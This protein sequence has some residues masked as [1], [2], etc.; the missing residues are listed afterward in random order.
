[1]ST[2][3]IVRIQ[4]DRIESPTFEGR[5]FGDTGPYEKLVG[6]AFAELDPADPLNSGI[7]D[8]DRAPRNAAGKVEYSTEVYIL[9]PVSMARGNRTLLYDVV[10]RGN[11]N[12]LT[13]FNVGAGGANDPTTAT[14]AGDGNLMN[15]G[16]TVVWSG[17]QGDVTRGAGRLGIELP[18]A[19]EADGSPIK[20]WITT[21]FV[22][23]EPSFSVPVSFDRDSRD[24]RP[25]PAVTES[26]DGARLYRRANPH[27]PLEE[28]PRSE[29]SFAK[30]DDGGAGTPSAVDVCLSAGF[31]TDW[32]Y[33]LVYEARDP[34][35][36]GIGFAATRD[37]VSFLRNDTSDGNPLVARGGRGAGAQP[38][39]WAIGFGS[40]QSGRY[41]K[42]MLYQGF[43]QDTAGRQVF[44]GL[45]PHITGSRRTFT[46]YE[47]AMPGRFS[48][49]VE[50]HYYPGDQ[51]PFTYETLTDPISGRTDGVL[52]RCREQGTC[53]KLMHWDSGTEPWAARASLV[54]TDPTGRYDVSIPANVR[55]YYFAST[56]HGPAA[57]TPTRGICQ[58][59]VNPNQYREAQRSLLA[60]LR[61]WVVEGREPPPTRYPSL[62]DGTLVRPLQEM[63]GFP[64][65]PGVRYTGRP[66]ELLIND[67]FTLPP[68]H[69]PGTEYTVLVPKV[70][71]DGNELGG[72][73]STTTQ[74]PLGTYTGW[75]LRRAGF[76]EDEGCYLSG[77]LI[78]FAQ[79][80][81]ERGDDPR[82]SIDERYAS[83]QVYV[84]RVRSAANQLRAD[85]F[86]LPQDA[87]RLVR[88]SEQRDIGI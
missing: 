3:G 80:A 12:A 10:N 39:D 28:I 19:T 47:F 66:N 71:E 30:C 25:N 73:R 13:T 75:G 48:T 37:L 88:E 34:L 83:K 33:E 32:Q 18:T 11:K 29:W 42:D 77:Q 20:R 61:G 16:Y 55:L 62:A 69:I 57:G 58:Q 79:T 85:R 68:R 35:V 59:L 84:D 78:P 17:W 72:I 14:D 38:V 45:I 52:Q 46:N 65:I 54:R 15:E 36:T 64:S 27:A 67:Y 51:F 63:V 60:T 53:P 49:Q 81:A 44:D 56:Q 41:L 8:L 4:I 7:V 76:M 23:S 9:K 74:V 40:S 6:R 2:S 86:L 1:V 70:D 87:D 82:P 5:S 31:S 26:M 22:L 43:N 50:G 21:E 24:V